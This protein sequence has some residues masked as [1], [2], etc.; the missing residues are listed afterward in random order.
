VAILTTI[1]ERIVGFR[2]LHKKKN[3]KQHKTKTK[4]KTSSLNKLPRDTE[5][6][7]GERNTEWLVKI[8]KSMMALCQ[9]M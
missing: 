8:E 4:T 3:Q 6:R 5:K 1:L 9:I 2:C 7:Q